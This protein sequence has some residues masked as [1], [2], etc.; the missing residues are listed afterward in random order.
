MISGRRVGGAKR[1]RRENGST[2]ERRTEG[3]GGVGEKDEGQKKG[4]ESVTVAACAS[5]CV[6]V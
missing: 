6:Y 5:T 3:E 2:K 1:R 4:E